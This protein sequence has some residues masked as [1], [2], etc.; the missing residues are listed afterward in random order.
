MKILRGID[1]DRGFS[2]WY[3]G[4]K[5][6]LIEFCTSSGASS[7]RLAVAWPSPFIS[8]HVTNQSITTHIP[9]LLCSHGVPGVLEKEESRA[10]LRLGP[11]RLG[12]GRGMSSISIDHFSFIVQAS[13]IYSLNVTYSTWRGGELLPCGEQ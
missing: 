9:Y 13:E 11:H 10:D 7:G 6:P 12:G 5:A 8:T 3:K 4:T 2:A 1:Y